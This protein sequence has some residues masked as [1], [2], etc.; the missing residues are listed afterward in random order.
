MWKLQCPLKTKTKSEKIRKT[1]AVELE[2]CEIA[3]SRVAF[4]IKIIY[5]FHICKHFYQGKGFK[6][7]KFI[8]Y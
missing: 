4:H 2:K 7:I 6:K 3:Q 8:F 5:D 1:A